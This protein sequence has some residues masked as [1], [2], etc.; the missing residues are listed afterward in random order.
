MA[1][2]P[3]D[4]SLLK[5]ARQISPEPGA[6][7]ILGDCNIHVGLDR[8]KRELN[9]DIVDTFD[10]NGEP[11]YKVDLNEPLDESLHRKYDWVIDSGTL[12]CCFD[13]STA[14][15]NILNIL[16]DE[17][18][19]VHTGN[20]SGFY[21]RGFYSLSPAFFRDF[22]TCNN[23]TIEMSATKTRT[24]RVWN[25]FNSQHTFLKNTNLS[26]QE[27]AGEFIPEI[28]ND[29]MIFCYAS[30]QERQVFTKPIPIHFVKTNGR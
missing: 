23:F 3:E 20:L 13:V 30:R 21:G 1:I 14:L 12:Y 10:I 4:F 8:F 7:A 5:E 22:Y 28:P 6:C 16:K 19:V 15:Q 17:G 25:K 29:S 2:E 9:F 18:N 11:T 27:S 26:F 24:S